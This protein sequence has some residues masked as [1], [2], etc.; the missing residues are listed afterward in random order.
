MVF[1]GVVYSKNVNSVTIYSPSC[2][3]KPCFNSMVDEKETFSKIDTLLF[4]I[5]DQ[6]VV[7]YEFYTIFQVF[8]SHVIA[9]CKEK[10]QI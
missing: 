7:R 10:A 3:F 8:C 5:Q 6:K 9:L 4:Y 2:H 1:K